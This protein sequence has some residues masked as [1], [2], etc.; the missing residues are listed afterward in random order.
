V[1][2]N[3]VRVSSWVETSLEIAIFVFT[4]VRVCVRACA[5]P[6][7]AWVWPAWLGFGQPPALTTSFFDFFLW[8]LLRWA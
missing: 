6:Q 8:V 3:A 5:D 1:G 7:P 2:G 4:T